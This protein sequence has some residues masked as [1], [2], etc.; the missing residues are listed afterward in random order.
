[1]AMLLTIKG[2]GLAL[3]SDYRCIAFSDSGKLRFIQFSIHIAL[4]A[5]FNG[6]KSPFR[7]L[8]FHGEFELS[9]FDRLG[10]SE[11]PHRIDGT[12]DRFANSIEAAGCVSHAIYPLYVAL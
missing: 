8:Y 4:W 11:L 1:M 2:I 12:C 7:L 6:H 10:R 5:V 3:Q 9:R